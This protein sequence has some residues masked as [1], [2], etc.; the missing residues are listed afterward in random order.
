MN[1]Q[2][3][4]LDFWSSLEEILN[5]SQIKI[6]RPKGTAHP[7]YPDFIYP[8]DYGYLEGTASMD[9][10]G[11]DI[12]RGSGNNGFDAILCVVDSVKKDSEIKILLN[13]TKEEK[14]KILQAQNTG[15]MSAILIN[16]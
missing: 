4:N 7:R 10:G 13:C 1:L 16:R 15:K 5:N 14:E 11:I 6:D 2:N 12:W 3:D 8:V 9:G